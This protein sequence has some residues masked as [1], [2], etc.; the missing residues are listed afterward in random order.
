MCSHIDQNSALKE[1]LGNIYKIEE[2]RF[3]LLQWFDLNG[4][5]WIPWKL[6]ADGLLPKEQEIL[7]VYPI[8]VAEVML[9]QT[10]LKVVL[11]FWEK[12][13]EAFPTLLD[14][15]LASEEDILL[16]WQGLGYYS[17]VHRMHSASKQLIQILGN[18]YSIEK[19]LWPTD[20]DSWITLPGIGRT[21]AASIISSAFNVPQ[22]ILDGNVIRILARLFGM[23]EV[24]PNHIESFWELSMLLLDHQ[25]PRNFN[26][27]LMDLGATIC[28]RNKPKCSD[29]P[30]QN[31]CFA[32]DEGDPLKFPLRKP[33][34][35]MQSLVI[36][37]GIVIN[38]SG[39]VLIDQ[40]QSNQSMAG[41]W[42]FPGGKNEL[43]E[44]IE[45]TIER[46]LYEELGI[47]VKVKE[48]IIEF[49]HLYTNKKLHF[50]VYICKIISGNP[51]PLASVQIKWVLPSELSN[52]PFPA[53]NQ[54]MISALKS[55]LMIG[56]DKNL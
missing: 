9:Q 4:R 16:H 1:R 32:Y 10:Q 51:K 8:F 50:V 36:G 53:A 21:T 31:Y 49:D 35:V 52:Y 46:E 13:I 28:T 19:D 23:K 24:I 7:P 30:L 42:E 37:I 17:R 54:K 18:H 56:K 25:S 44:L 6:N 3:S 14:L 2:L 29:C 15:A 22:A 40:R 41:L 26:Q 11:P 48:K 45:D 33:R 34:K 5:H 38:N 55:Y 12:W 27:A 20:I 43:D 47:K 39:Q